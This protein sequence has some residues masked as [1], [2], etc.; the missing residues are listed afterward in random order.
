LQPFQLIT[1]VL[2]RMFWHVGVH[3]PLQLC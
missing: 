3:T 2:V 1:L